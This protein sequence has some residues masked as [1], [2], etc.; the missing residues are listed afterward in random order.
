MTEI[1]NFLFAN[2]DLGYRDF[3]AP[4]CPTVD[5]ETII[6][7]R[8]PVLRK[9]ARSILKTELADA[10][11]LQLPHTYYDENQLHAFLLSEMTDFDAALAALERFLPYIDNWATCDQLN[12]KA[13]KSNPERLLPAIE[14][15]M[16]ST[17]TYTCRFG[18]GMLMR[19]FLDSRF[20]TVYLAR[21]AA[22]Q[23]EEY[24]VNM[25]C[26]W[27]FATALTKQYEATLPYFENHI[28]PAW[29]HNKAISKANDSLQIPACRKQT[30][31]DL[32]C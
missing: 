28:L 32:R 12:P 11:L 8:T 21:V 31:K 19:Y 6:G 15:W 4:L 9:Y 3:H 7:V 29:M 17:H 30:L 26:A 5:K 1:Q 25:M 10:F 22:V 20:D 24:Y 2:R 23:S 14:R 18:I 13:F 27:F 16:Q